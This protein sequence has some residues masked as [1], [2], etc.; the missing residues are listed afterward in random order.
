MW[1]RSNI[2]N[3]LEIVLR[4]SF[5]IDEGND[6]KLYLE[7]TAEIEQ[8]G[9]GEKPDLSFI[10]H[11]AGIQESITQRQ[12][13]KRKLLLKKLEKYEESLKTKNAFKQYMLVYVFLRLGEMIFKSELPCSEVNHF[14]PVI[15]KILIDI[16]EYSV[17]TI[18]T[19]DFINS[20][21]TMLPQ[22]V[23]SSNILK[24]CQFQHIKAWLNGIPK[25][26]MSTG[27]LGI[28]TSRD[29]LKSLLNEITPLIEYL[30][31]RGL[32]DFAF[33][34]PEFIIPENPLA[35]TWCLDENL[36]TDFEKIGKEN[37][38]NIL[39]ISNGNLED[40]FLLL[41][42]TNRH[43]R[44]G[45]CV[46]CE[47]ETSIICTRCFQCYDHCRCITKTNEMLV[48]CRKQKILKFGDLGRVISVVHY[49]RTCCIICYMCYSCCQCRLFLKET[50]LFSFYFPSECD[51]H[52]VISPES[53]SPQ[54][55]DSRIGISSALNILN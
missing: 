11:F 48:R 1:W 38:W 15:R 10:F 32:N 16:T 3:L 53:T 6:L 40:R 12:T 20:D 7:T 33:P 21:I 54:L 42:L 28:D 13:K 31:T 23:F 47:K 22:K 14:M 18:Y 52:L 29:A 30:K 36:L 4:Y 27:R 39:Q 45:Y 49:R 51:Y 2:S 9:A 8:I 34:P 46:S 37:N 19:I 35:K 41:S 50:P 5:L 25:L 44:K 17:I 43:V 26:N 24:V 55:V